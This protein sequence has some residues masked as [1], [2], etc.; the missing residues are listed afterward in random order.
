M[1]RVVPWARGV[2]VACLGFFTITLDATI[3]NVAAPS[4]GRHFNGDIT[5]LQWVVNG[6]VLVFAAALMSS[7]A[8]SDRIGAT[9][10]F[11]I[12]LTVFTLSSLACGLAP[13]AATLI[14][15]RVVQGAAASLILPSSLAIVRQVATDPTDLARGVALWA[16]G[17]GVAVSAGPVLGGVLTSQFGWQAIFLVNVPIG[18]AALVVL[19]GV[20][21][22][23][24]RAAPIDVAGQ[25]SGAVAMAAIT[26]AITEGGRVTAWALAVFAASAITFCVVETRAEHPAVPLRLFRSGP[27]AAAMSTG[28]VM[29]LTYFGVV[30]V[31]TFYFQRMLGLTPLQAGLMFVPMTLLTLFGNLS[32]SRL[33]ARYGVWFPLTFGQALEVL[34][35]AVLVV[36]GPTA[37]VA[38]VLIALVPIGFGAGV[39]SP[40]MTMALLGAA[41]TEHAGVAGGVLG[42]VRQL[43]GV[44]GVAA[45]GALLGYGFEQGMWLSLVVSLALLAVTTVLSFAYVR[46]RTADASA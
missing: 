33:I 35:F 16:T 44:L 3:V 8:L 24:R 15:A 10:A 21:R 20:T 22:S 31:L 34:G 23:E 9:R 17:G 43:G 1:S 7:G 25:L 41:P 4:I 38:V 30:F 29:N 13:T 27:V 36:A 46:P 32:A 6:Y 2:G 28:V 39:T 26:F 18:I 40:P 5:E 45:F 42:V 14:A 11:G 37:P 19:R 12:G